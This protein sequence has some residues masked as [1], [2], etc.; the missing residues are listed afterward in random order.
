MIHSDKITKYSPGTIITV[1]WIIFEINN[2]LIWLY[3]TVS[4]ECQHIGF[5]L[6]P[7]QIIF[8]TSLQGNFS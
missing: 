1:I 7:R 4:L 2:D 8:D 6:L 3:I 5:D